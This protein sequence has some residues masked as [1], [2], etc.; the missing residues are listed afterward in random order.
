MRIG[1]DAKRAFYNSRGLGNYSRDLIRILSE[2]NP[3][4]SYLLFY[5]KIDKEPLMTCPPHCEVALPQN[6]FYEWC[7]SLWRTA[8]ISTEYHRQKLDIF[9]GLSNEIPFQLGKSST[10]TVLTMHDL[11]FFKFPE[12]Y[13]WIDQ[14]IYQKKYLSSCNRAD[15]IIAIS[16]Q[17]RQDLIELAG[18]EESRIAVVHQGCNPIFQQKVAEEQI[19]EIRKK[20]HLPEQFMLNVGAIEERKNQSMIVEAM[21]EG[22]LDLPLVIV[23]RSVGNWG[24]ELNQRIANLN[25]SSN[26]HILNN[27][28]TSDLPALY[29][30]ASIFVYPSSYEG[31]GIPILEALTCGTPVVTSQGSCFEESGGPGSLYVNHRDPSALAFA[32]NQVLSDSSKRSQMIQDGFIHAKNFSDE[33][34]AK[35][36]MAVYTSL[37]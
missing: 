10:R 15:K 7:P 2:Q 32:L 9:H 6:S 13:P 22:K 1:F 28:P 16:E 17:T 29:R 35:N 27:V 3:E 8:G 14:F 5:A 26:V 30:M 24:E 36:L 18:I 11:I 37:L 21:A 20:Y 31:F 19:L 33:N 12:L 34:I 23:G 25:Q 4:N